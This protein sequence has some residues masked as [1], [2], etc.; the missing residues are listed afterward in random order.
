MSA[1]SSVASA[2][3]SPNA[4]PSATMRKFEPVLCLSST[5]CSMVRRAAMRLYGPVYTHADKH[6]VRN[7][8]RLEDI[9]LRRIC[10]DESH[11]ET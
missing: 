2:A 4:C 5:S 8:Y 3:S 11:I 1:P 6:R 9:L 7:A 10:T